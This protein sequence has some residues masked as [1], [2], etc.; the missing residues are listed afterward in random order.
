[1]T[2]ARPSKL[3]RGL[4]S[5]SILIYILWLML[6]MV[7]TTGRALTGV[8]ACG[9]L[10]LGVA[11]DMEYLKQQWLSLALRALCAAAMSVV[12]WVFLSRG[13]SNFWG[14]TC[15]TPCSGSR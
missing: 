2:L 10:V 3:S 9:L 15:S 1:M 6:P 12:L 7:Q 14:F 5:A 4:T 11:L 13:G 8:V